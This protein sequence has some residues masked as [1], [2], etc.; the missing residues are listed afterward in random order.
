M[1]SALFSRIADPHRC[2]V[3]AEIGSN[4]DG[5]FDTALRLMDIAR[6]AYADAVKFQSF[7]ADHLVTPANP[8]YGLLKRLEMP[9]AWYPRLKEA[10]EERGLV[11]F[12][13]ASN[14]VTL[15]WMEAI[16]V[17]LYKI[18]SPNLT[19]LPLIAKT[20]SFGKPVIMSA[21][22]AG[23]G[24]IDEAIRAATSV[25][26]EQLALLHCVS[27]YPAEPK[28]LNLRAIQ[29]LAATFPYPV[30]FSDH[31]L[32]IGTAVAAVTLGARVIEKHVTLDRD[33]SGPDHHYA[34]EP[35]S[36]IAMGQSIR[37]VEQALGDGHKIVTEIEA[38][39]T[40]SYW[41][42]LHAAQDL[43]ADSVLTCDNIAIVRP[44]DGLHPRELDAVIGL[45]LTRRLAAGEA[46]TW[47]A[48]KSI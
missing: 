18:G 25:G 48:F 14:D 2:F 34:L 26:N 21:G 32:D 46:I 22:M 47:D 7:L 15:G 38:A 31:S 36:F 16:G 3:V 17:E 8:N 11:F 24:E 40:M 1:P 28:L 10:A 30:G 43:A 19:H 27:V 6:E 23:M 37:T 39:N 20:A 29:T 45:R 4:H 5:D 33:R 42:S 9:R 13:T 12:S 41:R 44:N 35:K